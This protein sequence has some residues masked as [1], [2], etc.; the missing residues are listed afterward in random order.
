MNYG[1]YII[2]DKYKRNS[3]GVLRCS[4][5]A[6]QTSDGVIVPGSPQSSVEVGIREHWNKK[7]S[8]EIVWNSMK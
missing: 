7:V 6:E 2:L 8:Y 3:G 4:L 1:K 5:T